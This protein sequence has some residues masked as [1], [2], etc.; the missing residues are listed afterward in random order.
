MFFSPGSRSLIRDFSNKHNK[1]N[2][3]QRHREHREK[4]DIV[5]YAV[6]VVNKVT[7]CASVVK[8]LL[9]FDCQAI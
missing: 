6:G 9:A 3:P 7:L 8:R 2:S 5:N 4:L 1:N